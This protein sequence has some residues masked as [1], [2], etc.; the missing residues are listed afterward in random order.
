MAIKA[1]LKKLEKTTGSKKYISGNSEKELEEKVA[2]Y[3][4]KNPFAPEPISILVNRITIKNRSDLKK[5]E[6]L[7]EID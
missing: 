6:G 2:A 5:I 4:K 1:R 7:V 3:M